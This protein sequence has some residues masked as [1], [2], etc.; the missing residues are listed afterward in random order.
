MSDKR[1]LWRIFGTKREELTG[2][3]EKQ[4]AQCFQTGKYDMG[5]TRQAGFKEELR[6][7]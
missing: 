2:R 6:N 4:Q 7:V 3:W 5:R 1:V